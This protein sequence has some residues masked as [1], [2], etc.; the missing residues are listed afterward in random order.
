MQSAVGGDVREICPIC[1]KRGTYLW[2][3]LMCDDCGVVIET[4]CEGERDCRPTGARY[5][6]AAH[7]STEGVRH[8]TRT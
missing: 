8:G 1:G 6:W 7:S 4:C 2:S 5:N 3:K